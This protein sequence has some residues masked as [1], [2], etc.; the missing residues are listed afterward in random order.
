MANRYDFDDNE[1]GVGAK[2]AGL[3]EAVGPR[4]TV[5]AVA[6]AVLIL[7][8]VIWAS[9][10]DGDTAG[11]DQ[12]VPIVRADAGEFKT[13]PDDPGGLQI[14]HRDS[15]VFGAMGSDNAG[16]G[17]ENLLADD[18]SEEPVPKSQLF[19]GLNTD[20]VPAEVADSAPAQPTSAEATIPAGTP[21]ET[22][23]AA[24][25]AS[26]EQKIAEG[27]STT[28]PAA[29]AEKPA[30]T[31]TANTAAAPTPA[32]AEKTVDMAQAAQAA[33]QLEPTS[34]PATT[35]AAAAKVE[36]A[37]GAA[38]AGSFYVQV[39]SVKEEG[40]AADEWKKIQAKYTSLNSLS[41]R[42]ERADLGAKGVFYRIQAGPVS[43]DQAAST[44]D[45][46][47][48]VTPGGCLVVAD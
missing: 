35:A 11:A 29:G 18:S 6:L 4:F 7:G 33:A 17:V 8:G 22:A 43:K 40:K 41:H 21:S 30:E 31:T 38:S 23:E 10:P 14:A 44:C 26:I 34:G 5:G 20:Q 42:V 28:E 15:T 27:L 47:K 19:A 45:A 13:A 12:A 32:P 37:A 46:I 24:K 9:Y 1:G 36:P 3:W 39:G 16:E 48:K 25:T 2:L